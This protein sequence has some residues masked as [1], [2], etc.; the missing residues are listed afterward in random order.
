MNYVLTYGSLRKGMSNHGFLHTAN[1][2]DYVEIPGYTM[3]SFGAFPALVPGQGPGCQDVVAELYEVDD[4]TLRSLDMLEGYPDF[5]QRGEVYA[6]HY[7][8]AWIYFIPDPEL[9]DNPIVYSG[10][11]SG[12]HR[13][14]Y[15]QGRRQVHTA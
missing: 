15:E 7:G 13:G 1:F 14:L 4:S 3:V 6:G 12:S 2:I 8:Y 9:L 10:D 11:W 5:Y